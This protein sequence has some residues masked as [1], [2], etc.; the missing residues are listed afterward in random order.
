MN[1]E[2]S[3]IGLR[4]FSGGAA[5]FDAARIVDP[6]PGLFDPQNPL[7]HAAPVQVGGRKSA[8]FV[9]AEFG[10]AVLR[11]YRRGGMVAKLSRDRYVWA[12]ADA[13]RSFAEFRVLWFLR[14]RGLAVPAP[15]AAAYWKSGLTYRA[16]ILIERIPQVRTLAE[17][18]AEP[19]AVAKAIFAMHEAGVWHADLNA[20]NILL[21]SSGQVW[22]ID[23]DRARRRT[24]TARLRRSNL[25]RLKRSLDKVAGEPGLECWRQIHNA[26]LQLSA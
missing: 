24:L 26:Y 6:G 16:A 1:S 15:L 13:T 10:Q 19:E 20:F 14:E 12:G 7:L 18:R 21:S 5:C 11:H 2:L 8:W 17:A 25:L 9:E 22:L 4:S 23:F 3:R